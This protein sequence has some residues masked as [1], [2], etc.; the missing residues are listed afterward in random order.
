MHYGLLSHSFLFS[1]SLSHAGELLRLHMLIGKK[2]DKRVWVSWM[3]P[4]LERKYCLKDLRY[5]SSLEKFPVKKSSPLS[6]VN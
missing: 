1:M 5:K 6:R 3:L 4:A 2:E